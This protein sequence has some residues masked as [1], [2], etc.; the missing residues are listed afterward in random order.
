MGVVP[1]D[2]AVKD[3]LPWL[4]TAVIWVAIALIVLD[5]AIHARTSGCS[6][7]Y[8]DGRGRR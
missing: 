2:H 5:V 1:G 3:A 4:L 6:V 7:I 8:E